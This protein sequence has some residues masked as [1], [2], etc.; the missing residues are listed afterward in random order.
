MLNDFLL[1]NESAILALT[2]RK[3]LE[4]AGDHPSSEQLKSGLPIFY[5]QIIRVIG[6]PESKVAPAKDIGAIA[7]AADRGDEPAM[8]VAAGQPLAGL[9]HYGV[10]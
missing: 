5:R 4:L 6:R 2:E 10:K 9:V 7:R 1:K 8:A 3:A